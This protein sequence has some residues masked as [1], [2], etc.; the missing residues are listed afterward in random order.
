MAAE[1]MERKETKVAVVKHDTELS[2]GIWGSSDNWL[3]AGQMAKAL[4]CSTIVPKDYQGNEANALV[5]IDIANRLQT[6]PLMVMQN[7]HVIQGRPSWSAQFLIASVNGSGKYN[8]ELQYDEKADKAG[9]PYSC[10]CWTMK[11][12]RRVTGPVIDMEMAKAEGWTTKSMSKWKTMPQIMLR[13]RAASFFARM[14]CPELTLGFYT[15]EEVI[16]GE[17]KEYPMEEMR[18]SVEKEIKDNA[19]TE[20]FVE[21]SMQEN[22]VAENEAGAEKKKEARENGEE[23]PDFMKG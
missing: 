3:M 7:L 1:V 11:D 6:S 16:D 23:V 22:N 4:S 15:K 13:Y 20:D 5:A 14:N 10:Q 19:N 12:G 17:F 2:K 9:K 21:A 18:Q 8:M